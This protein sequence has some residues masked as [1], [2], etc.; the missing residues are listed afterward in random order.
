MPW[1]HHLIKRTQVEVLLDD[2]A[3][4]SPGSE[5]TLLNPDGS[6]FAASNGKDFLINPSCHHVVR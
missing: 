3:A 4:L 1:L 5:F 6:L 2:F